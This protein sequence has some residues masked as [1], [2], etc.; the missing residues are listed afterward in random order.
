MRFGTVAATGAG[1]GVL[2][3]DRARAAHGDAGPAPDTASGAAFVKKA[4]VLT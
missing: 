3:H 4:T 2:S 1:L